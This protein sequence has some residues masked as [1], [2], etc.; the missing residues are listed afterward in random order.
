MSGDATSLSVVDLNGSFLSDLRLF[1][2]EEAMKVSMRIK[3][4]WEFTDLT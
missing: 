1:D 4:D 3:V 2:I